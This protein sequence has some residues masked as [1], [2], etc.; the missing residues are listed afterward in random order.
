MQQKDDYGKNV[1]YRFTALST[2]Y[3][4][5]SMSLQVLAFLQFCQCNPSSMQYSHVMDTKLTVFEVQEH[6]MVS[7][8]NAI[9]IYLVPFDA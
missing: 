6:I 8:H 7:G 3:N 5:R 2:L 4:A 1:L 9:I